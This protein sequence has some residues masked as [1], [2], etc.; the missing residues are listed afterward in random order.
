MTMREYDRMVLRR[1]WRR[2][3]RAAGEFVGGV[4]TMGLFALL[5]WAFIWLTPPQ[6]SAEADWFDYQMQLQNGGAE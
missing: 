1:L 6:R 5:A 3:L 4:V 2:R